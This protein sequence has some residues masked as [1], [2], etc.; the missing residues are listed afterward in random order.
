ME[1]CM[2]GA[3]PRCW[4]AGHEPCDLCGRKGA[5][6]ECTPCEVC[7]ALL[8]DGAACCEGC[9]NERDGWD[10]K[11]CICPPRCRGRCRG[12]C[13]CKACELRYADHWLSH[14]HDRA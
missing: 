11:P 12:G 10:G 8:A 1:P 13:G 9:I 6:C 2:C 5:D 3:C 4:P 7:G 14:A